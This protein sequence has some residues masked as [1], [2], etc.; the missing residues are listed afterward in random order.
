MSNNSN[1]NL[2]DNSIDDLG[3]AI[4]T[5]KPRPSTAV[6]IQVPDDVLVQLQDLAERQN[7]SLSILLKQYI[8]N[9]LRQDIAKNYSEHVRRRARAVLAQHLSSQSEIE[10]ILNEI[11]AN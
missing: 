4:L 11:T 9:G 5:V 8:G 2:T 6:T 1:D 7:I 3:D 10:Q